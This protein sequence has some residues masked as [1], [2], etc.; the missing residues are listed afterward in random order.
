M[1]KVPRKNFYA[2]R[3]GREGPKIYASWDECRGVTHG[4]SGASFK[5]FYSRREA[6]QWLGPLV[7][8]PDIPHD[9]WH[10]FRPDGPGTSRKARYRNR[11]PVERSPY[12]RPVKLEPAQSEI[13][14]AFAHSLWD[15][16]L[17]KA[18]TESDTL[19]TPANNSTLPVFRSSSPDNLSGQSE[20]DTPPE[21]AIELS[22]EQQEVLDAV[23]AGR[24]IFFTGSAGTGKSVLLRAIIKWCRDGDR[25]LA[26]TASTGI[27]AVNIGGS[28]LH[29]WAGIG[30]G[31]ETAERLVWKILGSDKYD[32]RR[33][34]EKQ[35][36]PFA[37]D[38][39]DPDNHDDP[40]ALLASRYSKRR[41]VQRWRHVSTLIIDEI[42]MIDG[43]LFDK[44]EFIARVLRKNN[45]PFGGIQLIVSGDFCQLPPVPDHENGAPVPSTFAFDARTWNLCLGNIMCL[46]KVFRQKEQEFVDMLNAMRFGKLLPETIEAFKK[47]SR[48]VTYTDNIEP[49]DLFSTR[50]EVDNANQWRLHRL[51]TDVHVYAARDTPGYDRNYN[52]V[53]PDVMEKLLDRL[54]AQKSIT[55]KEGAQVMLIKNLVQGSLVNGT[56]GKVVKFLTT[57]EA[58]QLGIK[59]GVPDNESSSN[60]PAIHSWKIGRHFGMHQP[61]DE[62][63]RRERELLSKP[64]LYPVV[65]FNQGSIHGGPIEVLCVPNDFEVNTADGRVE[66]RREQ[67]P[68]ILAWALSIHKSQGQTLERV[69]VDLGS[70]FEKGQAYVALSRAT[71]MDTLEVRNFDPAKVIAHQR[72]LEWTRTHTDLI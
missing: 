45:Q 62:T 1:P 27:A 55:L 53:K 70:I 31:K 71:S 5:G 14:E 32:E 20:D 46:K 8:V 3:S 48:R 13:P 7:P 41:V 69:R 56:I 58:Q 28:T 63:T 23:K 29:S 54:V 42:S 10:P 49:T 37:Y 40:L 12:A 39:Y 25:E 61:Q 21:P 57:S 34:Q 2:V 38:D 47:L 24:S 66:A 15:S 36:K 33:E 43:K 6:E 30:L 9:V 65:W 4:F 18:E 50:E 16:M 35:G 64:G 52:E 60:K 17:P 26:V 22:P 72:V 59:I 51:K 67:V 44:L 68:L 19:V 11:N